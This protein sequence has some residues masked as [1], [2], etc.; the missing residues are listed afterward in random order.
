MRLLITGGA[1]Y[2]GSHLTLM[3]ER[4]GHEVWIYDNFSNSSPQMPFLL[5]GLLGRNKVHYV[6]GDV[7]DHALLRQTMYIQK[8]D[9]VL[10]LAAKKYADESVELPLDY[11]GTNVAGTI[12]VLTAMR[13][14]E[15]SQL[16]FSSSAAVYGKQL[17][18]PIDEQSPCYPDSPYGWSKLMTERIIRHSGINA[19]CL[20]Y[21]NPIGVSPGLTPPDDPSLM[22]VILS[23]ASGRRAHM[24]VFGDDWPTR[25]GTAIRDFV[26]VEDVAAAHLSFLEKD[27]FDIFNV[28]TGRGVTVGELIALAEQEFGHGI[29]REVVGR[30]GGD[31][32]ESVA[33]VSLIQRVTGWKAKRNLHDMVRSTVVAESLRLSSER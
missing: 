29:P 18:T 1:G 13:N 25:D 9:V 31:I 21:F 22:S 17:F 27:G 11:Y 28:G 3:A 32:G 12:S 10:H 33:D 30:R 2:V 5:G 7:R 8:T 4:A 24:S 16:V 26:H 15:V 23:V 14:S 6:Q 20:R 19:T